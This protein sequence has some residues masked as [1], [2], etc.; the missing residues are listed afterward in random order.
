[1]QQRDDMSR[2]RIICRGKVYRQNNIKACKNTACKIN[3]QSGLGNALEGLVLLA[4]ENR[5]NRVRSKKNGQ[6]YQCR[7]Q[8]HGAHGI[9]ESTAY[10]LSVSRAVIAAHK[11]LDSL[12]NTCINGNYH[13]RKICN[14]TISCNSRVSCKSQDDHIKYDHNDS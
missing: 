9:S 7:Y 1:S 12:G 2:Q 10:I 5:S 11:R 3:P 14:Y 4:V 8:D 6:I 13:Q